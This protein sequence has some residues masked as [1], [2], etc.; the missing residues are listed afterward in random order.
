MLLG[1]DEFGR[2]QSGNNNAYCQDNA[3]SWYDWALAEENAGSRAL[4]PA[5]DFALRKTHVVLRAER[6]YTP[7]EIEWV[8]P[9]G[10]PPDWQ[11]PRNR[12]D[13]SSTSDAATLA[14]L[15]NSAAEACVFTL[16]GEPTRVWQV[17]IDTARP[18]PDDAPDPTS[19]PQ[20]RDAVAMQVAPH[21]LLVLRAL[22]G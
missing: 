3:I 2:T 18:T 15:F 17:C 14:L 9:F 4:R 12:L 21:S 16:P 20:I 8:G 11:G 22:P 10:Q 7:S 13:V 19:A 5:A 6:F 1:G